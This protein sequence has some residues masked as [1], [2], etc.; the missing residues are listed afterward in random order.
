MSGQHK[1]ARRTPSAV[2]G[3]YAAIALSVGAVVGVGVAGAA[4][5][6]AAETQATATATAAAAPTD[7]S[8]PDKQQS[9]HT[10]RHNDH[11]DMRGWDRPHRVWPGRGH[12]GA[13]KPKPGGTVSVGGW[14][15][16][17][18]VTARRI[19]R[20]A[21][22]AVAQANRQQH[23][24]GD[25]AYHLVSV[26]SAD[27][28]VVAGTNYRLQIQVDHPSAETVTAVVHVMPWENVRTLTSFEP[29]STGTGT[30]PGTPHPG[31]V[32]GWHPVKDVSDPGVQAA[33]A[34]AVAQANRQ[35]HLTGDAA[36][37]LVSV[38]SADTQVV[39]GM[40]YRLQIQVD[41]PSAE[42]V[43]AVVNDRPWEHVRT[44]MSFAPQPGIDPGAGT[45][46]VSPKPVAWLR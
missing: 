2:T 22:W 31:S 35:Q 28:Q 46:T 39:A 27:T 36:Y 7:A 44:L 21:A 26:K 4:P 11:D 3:R 6:L 43:L 19:Q 24:T 40:N 32:G 16:V 37:H 20:L 14:H 5:A 42:L 25:A 29:Q 9:A 10:G 17:K 15:P 13:G 8:H 38:K 41:H 23:L 18:D 33:A 12:D 1:K 30:D 34:W 45:V